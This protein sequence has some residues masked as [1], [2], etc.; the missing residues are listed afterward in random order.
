MLISNKREIMI[1]ERVHSTSFCEQDP[2][3]SPTTPTTNKGLNSLCYKI[4]HPPALST[5]KSN[6]IGAC[7]S[8]TYTNPAA[9]SLRH[10]CKST[11]NRDTYPS[12]PL[13]AGI[14]VICL[15]LTLRNSSP[16]N[17]P[18]QTKE[19]LPAVD[20]RLQAKHKAHPE[21]PT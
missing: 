19:A 8:F 20:I 12:L 1:D 18:Q 7:Y 14:N 15:M 4:P 10:G 5:C 21:V 11:R 3:G 16:A 17:S 9:S 13:D 2:T 6:I